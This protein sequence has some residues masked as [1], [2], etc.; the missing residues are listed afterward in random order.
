M[1]ICCRSGNKSATTRCIL[2]SVMAT[3]TYL[4]SSAVCSEPVGLGVPDCLT[5]NIV[6][7][8]GYGREHHE[9]EIHAP[10]EWHATQPLDGFSKH[11]ARTLGIS[12]AS[13]QSPPGHKTPT[14]RRGFT[15][16]TASDGPR[17]AASSKFPPTVSPP[18]VT[19]GLLWPHTQPPTP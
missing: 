2:N 15:P 9:N 6:N 14:H 5:M 19:E 10:A 1:D 17:V 3:T 16:Q 8:Q 4:A 11:G 18:P 7:H 13:P 12:D